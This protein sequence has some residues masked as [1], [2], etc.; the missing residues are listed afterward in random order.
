MGGNKSPPTFV[1]G[2]I[3]LAKKKSKKQSK[4]TIYRNRVLA[5]MRRLKKKGYT[6]D[7]LYFPTEREVRKAG[8]KGQELRYLTLRLKS[9]SSKELIKLARRIESTYEDERFI[10]TEYFYDYS[11]VENFRSQVIRYPRGFATQMLAWI[12]RVVKEK[13]IKLASEMLQDGFSS[14][15][16]IT[17]ETMYKEDSFNKFIDAMMNFIPDIGELEKA[18]ILEMVDEDAY[19]E[20]KQRGYSRYN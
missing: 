16:E 2:M 8:V 6:F 14:G 17:A 19:Q 1:K 10:D 9:Y 12:N 5:T 3:K 20:F 13:G 18:N 15:L 11:V 7:D 4:Y